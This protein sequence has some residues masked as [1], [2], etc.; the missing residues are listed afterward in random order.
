MRF[1]PPDRDNPTSIVPCARD[2]AFADPRYPGN[3]LARDLT[4]LVEW[5]A[6]VLLWCPEITL[7]D[8]RVFL[9]E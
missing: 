4:Q 3:C 5:L 1:P 8:F 9:P 7:N 2:E 6:V